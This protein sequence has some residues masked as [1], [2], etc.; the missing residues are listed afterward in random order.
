MNSMLDA[1]SFWVFVMRMMALLDLLKKKYSINIKLSLSSIIILLNFTA[2][3]CA[4]RDIE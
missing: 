2:F 4:K 3:N 1:S